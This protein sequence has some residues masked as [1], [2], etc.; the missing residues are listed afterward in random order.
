MAFKDFFGKVFNK[1]NSSDIMP[2]KSE[3][4]PFASDAFPVVNSVI[5]NYRYINLYHFQD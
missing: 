1:S 5:H 4:V 3:I 2:E